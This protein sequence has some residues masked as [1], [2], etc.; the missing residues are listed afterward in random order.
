MRF[1]SLL[2]LEDSGLHI[3]QVII[4]S[5]LM[6]YA[7]CQATQSTPNTIVFCSPS[8]G[9]VHFVSLFGLTVVHSRA[10]DRVFGGI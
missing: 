9:C 3:P 4:I 7:I 8:S 5:E 2:T 6:A 1:F 10:T